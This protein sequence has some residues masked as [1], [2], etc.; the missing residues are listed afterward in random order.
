M[1]SHLGAAGA[2]QGAY[3]EHLDIDNEMTGAPRRTLRD[4]GPV[5]GP[6]VGL[7]VNDESLALDVIERV[8]IGGSF[9]GHVH[10]RQHYHQ[11][12]RLDHLADR[13]TWDT[14][15]SADGQDMLQH[16]A[17]E[18]DRLLSLPPAPPQQTEQEQEIA[19]L[20]DAA[21]KELNA[22]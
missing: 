8:G 18:V 3:L 6:G 13:T 7:A 2:D 17:S 5:F 19:A 11:G 1:T 14:W 20:L 22:A 15:A 10:T 12:T 4:L 21:L 9:L 16:A